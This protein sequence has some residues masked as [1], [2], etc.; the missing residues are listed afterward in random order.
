MAKDRVE[1]NIE[2]SVKAYIKSAKDNAKEYLDMAEEVQKA[3]DAKD[4]TALLAMDV[5]T[6]DEALYME[7]SE[8]D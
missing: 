1:R 2:E 5:I 6:Y 8:D 7:G 4:W 3:Y